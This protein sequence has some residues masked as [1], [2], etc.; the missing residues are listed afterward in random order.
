MHTALDRSRGHT[1]T[2]GRLLDGHSLDGD[3]PERILEILAQP[4]NRV[5]GVDGHRPTALLEGAGELVRRRLELSMAEP[6]LA[7]DQ[8]A[9]LPGGDPPEPAGHGRFATKRPWGPPHIEESLL[10]DLLGLFDR[11]TITAKPERQEPGM[12]VIQRTKC[13][14]ISSRQ[15]LEQTPVP[16]ALHIRIVAADWEKVP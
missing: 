11:C 14:R 1:Q 13:I 16:G 6:D 15:P 10:E 7:P 12:A 2:I 3:S 9:V 8:H 4:A 5:P